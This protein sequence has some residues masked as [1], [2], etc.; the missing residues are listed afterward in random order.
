MSDNLHN[1]NDEVLEQD[2]I[3]TDLTA[4]TARV[5]TNETDITTIN[6]LNIANKF[7]GSVSSGLK[8][9][10][11]GNDTD[12]ANI[13]TK[14][15][16]VSVSQNVDL[17]QM[18]TDIGVNNAKNSYPS[19]DAT[20]VGNISVSS[21]VNLNTMNTAITTNTNAIDA[22]ELKTDF[23]S[24]TQNVNLDTVENDTMN[25][26]LDIAS[27]KTK[28]DLITVNGNDIYFGDK[29]IGINTTNPNA[30]LEIGDS[31]D[32]E[33][34]RLNGPNGLAISSELLFT[35][36]LGSNTAEY[37]NGAGIR[38]NSADNSLQFITDAGDDGTAEI[39]MSIKRTDNF[40]GINNTSPNFNLDVN[41][42]INCQKQY[43]YYTSGIP[44]VI[45]ITSLNSSTVSYHRL[46][47][48]Q[49]SAN[50]GGSITENTFYM[51]DTNFKVVFKPFSSKVFVRIH[52]MMDR[53]FSGRSIY[54]ALGTS[55]SPSS[56]IG[57]TVTFSRGGNSE[58]TS[59]QEIITLHDQGFT[60][61]T[62]YVR[63]IFVK[64]IVVNSNNTIGTTSGNT[65]WILWGGHGTHS[66]GGGQTTGHYETD[67]SPNLPTNS[68]NFGPLEAVVYGVADTFTT[69]ASTSNPM[70]YIGY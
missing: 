7:A 40:I 68:D 41:G 57:R 9:L 8:T 43:H 36:Q 21:A 11:E 39:A 19:G 23:I 13:K 62:T 17:D 25:N 42:E 18:E 24:I 3:V 47:Y 59:R 63:Y 69:S 20:K 70:Q 15:D 22:V 58:W 5:G 30:S 37:Y 2:Q 6:N 27:I 46:G 26:S 56:I 31:T 65:G 32:V 10:I 34:I 61:F 28:T 52:Y 53:Y 4:L 33:R 60:P 67:S 51:P 66:D 38:Y 35:D 45:G 50:G 14:T 1:F 16:F 49:G 44:I 48:G 64:S 54:W 29:N 55:S 12:I